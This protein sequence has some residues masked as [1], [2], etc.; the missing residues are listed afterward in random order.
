MAAGAFALAV[1]ALL[2]L[3]PY[4]T[5]RHGLFGRVGPHPG[6]AWRVNAS[7]A[8]DPAFN[9]AVIGNSRMQML[10]PWTLDALTGLRFVNLAVP[11]SAPEEMR[12]VALAFLRNHPQTGALVMGVDEWWCEPQL[13]SREKFPAW[14]YSDDPVAYFT[15][16]LRWQSLEMIPRRLARLLGRSP[17]ARPD[18]YEDYTVHYARLTGAERAQRRMQ[19]GSGPWDSDNPGARFPAVAVLADILAAAPAGAPVALVWPPTHVSRLPQPGSPAATTAALCR[20]ALAEAAERR[21]RVV[22]VDW[23]GDLPVNRDSRN[24]HDETHYVRAVAE[25]LSAAV[26]E[27]LA[28]LAQDAEGS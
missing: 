26:G 6:G 8:A 15:G 2:A 21:G 25:R 11:G 1:A 22:F 28:R 17:A 19:D 24:F 16:L 18:G 20:K 13:R 9:A 12:L 27:A 5:G 10:Q 7:R 3:D 14:L 23:G 4:D